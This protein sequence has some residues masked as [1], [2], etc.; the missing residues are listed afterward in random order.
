MPKKEK[1]KSWKEI[2]RERQLKQQRAQE[3]E[4]VRLE[5]EREYKKG[6]KGYACM[7]VW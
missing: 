3:G 4:H 2:Q 5:V 7:H 6:H 1:K